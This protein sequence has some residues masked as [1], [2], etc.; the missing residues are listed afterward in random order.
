MKMS[1]DELEYAIS[2]YIDGTLTTLETD[3]LEKRLASDIEARAILAEYRRLDTA[4]RATTTPAVEWDRLAERISSSV[5]AAEAP[6][7][8]T[9]RI[10]SMGWVARVS[11]AASLVFAIGI[12]VQFVSRTEPAIRPTPVVAVSG[13][14]IEGPAGPVVAKISIGPSP[15]VAHNW[16]A[17]EEV[18]SRPT[19]VLIDRAYTYGQDSDSGLY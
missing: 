18:V 9:Y 1:L 2:Q 7:I 11:V 15:A 4:M 16:R 5:A 8:A 17:S 13:P 19:V 10:R 14:Q 3:S 6:P 12:V